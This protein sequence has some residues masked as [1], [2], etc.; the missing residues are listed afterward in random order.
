M[1][2]DDTRPTHVWKTGD[3]VRIT[4]EGRTV[5]GIVLL[6]AANGRSLMLEFEAILAG[7]VGTMPVLW[8]PEGH[9]FRFLMTGVPVELAAARGFVAPTPSCVLTLDQFHALPADE[10]TPG[11]VVLAV[12]ESSPGL[13][14]KALKAV[15]LSGAVGD[16]CVYVGA[17]PAEWV[18]DHGYKIPFEMATVMFAGIEERRYRP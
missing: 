3:A 16:Y 13:P 14:G 12:A 5:P 15:L 4:C 8:D 1:D 18:A 7:A 6:A 10:V 2:P 11:H 9:T 17:G